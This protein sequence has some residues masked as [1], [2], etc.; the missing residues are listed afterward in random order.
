[1]V[2]MPHGVDLLGV[3]HFSAI[4]LPPHDFA[5]A[6]ARAGFGSIGLRLHPAFQG[7]P[8]YELP[9]GSRASG[10]FKS[11]L[12]TEGLEVF[13]IEFFVIDPSFE[14]S[15]VERVIECAADLGASRLSVCGDDWDRG[16][17][18]ANFAALCAIAARH[19]M[20]VDIENMGWRVIKTFQDGAALVKDAGAENAGVLVDGIH[21]FRNGATVSEFREHS[22]RVAHVQLCDARGP[23]PRTNEEMIAEARGGRLAPG[24]GE[25]GLAE[26][27]AATRPGTRFSVEVPLTGDKAPDDHLSRLATAA[28]SLLERSRR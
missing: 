6:A 8:Y 15:A 10:E 3:A 27:V 21:F 26:L 19:G 25:L 16:R 5:R 13:D 14:A 18:V 23:A 28:K 2:D 11:V 12:D 20:S 24:A 17:L 7:A 9:L 1:M 22:W 4:M